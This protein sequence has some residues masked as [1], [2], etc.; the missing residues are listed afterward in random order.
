MFA[1]AYEAL[2]AAISA[3]AFPGAAVAITHCGKLV[4]LKGFGHFTYEPESPAVGRDTIYDLASV[5]K[6]VATTTMAMV[7]YEQGEL[8]LEMPFV[9]LLPEFADNDPRRSQ[10][11]IQMLLAHSSGLPAYVR[12]FEQAHT[13]RLH[14]DAFHE[15]E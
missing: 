1:P 2:E 6:V 5:S 11:T 15:F 8:D 13:T 12:L 10:I 7:L 4:A 9:S 3:K 14:S